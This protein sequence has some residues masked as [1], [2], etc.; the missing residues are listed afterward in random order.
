MKVLFSHYNYY[1]D[2]RLIETYSH[3]FVRE[4]RASGHEVTETGKARLT[5]EE[6]KQYD[7]F[8]D[9]DCGKGTDQ[10]Y[11]FHLEGGALPIK[12]AI[13]LI[14][15]HGKPDYH[16]KVATFADHVFFAVWDKRDLFADHPSA[17]WFPNFTDAH[18]F[19]GKRQAVLSDVQPGQFD[20][21]FFGTKGGLDRADPL[22]K[23]CKEQG[24]TYD[25]DEIG[26]KGKHR[27]P[28]T[29][30]R[31]AACRFGFNHG[32]KHDGPNLRV[33]ETM[34][35]K[36]PL[37]CDKDPRDGKGYLFEPWQHYIP[38]DAYTY[39]GLA[40]RM[41]WCMKNPDKAAKIAEQAYEEVFRNH[42]VQHRVKSFLEVVEK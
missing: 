13:I 10:Q 21:C 22:V 29:A 7:L 41:A 38:Y 42:L 31:M 33:M 27:W 24:Y 16:K 23:I 37:I 5:D 17:T 35:M 30:K 1:Y 40:E 32:Q 6:Y 3:S 12:S 34:A 15:S 28:N 9:V 14:D 36:L 39:D 2:N 11:T 26:R 8:V 19:D 18:H 4:L 20:F 25:V